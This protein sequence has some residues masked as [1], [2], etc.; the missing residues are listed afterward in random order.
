MGSF[1]SMALTTTCELGI[2]EIIAKAGRGSKLSATDI[3]AQ[4][5]TKNQAAPIMVDRIIETKVMPAGRIANW[6]YWFLLLLTVSVKM[7]S[8]PVAIT[9][10]ESNVVVANNRMI[11]TSFMNK[12]VNVRLDDNNFLLWKQHVLLMIQGHEL[13]ESLSIPPQ[14]I[15]DDSGE[16]IVN[17]TYRQHKK[18]NNS[19]AYWIISIISSSILP[20]LVGAHTSSKIW[21]T[22]LSMYSKLSTTK[23]MSLHGRLRSLK[24]GDFSVREFSTQI[25]EICDLLATSGSLVSEIDHFVTLLNGLPVDFESF[26]VAINVSREPYTFDIVT[27]VLIDVE[28]QIDDLMKTS[29]SISLT[30]HDHYN[31]GNAGGSRDRQSMDTNEMQAN[32]C[33]YDANSNESSYNPFVST[34][35]GGA[36]H[37]VTYEKAR[38]SSGR[39]YSGK[40]KVYLDDGSTLPISHLTQDNNVYLEFHS[41]KCFVKD[42]ETDRIQLEVYLINRLPVDLLGRISPFEKLYGKKPDYQFLRV[43]G[44][45]FF[46]VFDPSIVISLTSGL[47]RVCFLVTHHNIT[48]SVH[49]S[50]VN[51]GHD[52]RLHTVEVEPKVVSRVAAQLEVTRNESMYSDVVLRD[53]QNGSVGTQESSVPSSTD[54]L[55]HKHWCATVEMEFKALI[56]N[57]TWKLVPLPADRKE[58]GYECH[59]EERRLSSSI[60]ERPVDFTDD[61][62]WIEIDENAMTN[63]HLALADEI[64][65][66]KKF[67]QGDSSGAEPAHDEQESESF[68][69]PTTRQSDR[70][71]MRPNWHSNYVIEGNIAY[72]LLTEDGE[73]STFQEPEGFEEK[74]K[75]NLVCRLNKSLYDLKQALRCWYKRFDSFIMCLGYNRLNADPCAYFKRFGDNDF[76]ILL[77]YVDDMLVAGPNKDHIEELKAQLAS[78]FEMKD[79]GSAN[80]ILGIQIHRER[81]NRKIWLSQKNYL[82]NILSRFN[83]QDLGSLMFAM[84]CTRPDIA[85]AVGVVS[86][87][88]EN[89]DKEHW[90]TAKRRFSEKVKGRSTSVNGGVQTMATN[91]NSQTA[92]SVVRYGVTRMDRFGLVGLVQL[93]RIIFGFGLMGAK[94]GSGRI[95]QASHLHLSLSK[96]TSVPISDEIS[97]HLRRYQSPSPAKSFTVKMEINQI[98]TEAWPKQLR[99]SFHLHKE[100]FEDTCFGPW[101]KV[102]HP[103]GDAMLTHLFLQTMTSDLPET[104]Q[105]HDEEIWFD[106]PPAYTCF[107]REE[108]CLITGPTLRHDDVDRYTRHITAYHGFPVFPELST[109]KSNLHV[110]DLTRLLNKKDGFTRMDDVDV[111]RDSYLWR[112]TWNKLSSAFNDRKSLRGDGSKY[113]LSDFIWAFKIWIFEAF[114]A[115]QTYALKTSNDIPRVISWKR[116]RSLQQWEDLLPYTTINNEPPLREPS[117]HPKPSPDRPEYTP[118]QRES[119]PILSHYRASSPPSPHD[120]RPAK[121]PR[122]L[123]PCS[124]SSPPR[125]ELGELRNEVNALREEVGTLRDDNGAWRIKVSTLRGEVAALREIV[126]SLQ[127]ERPAKV[128]A[129][130]RVFLARRSSRIRRRA[131]AITSPFTPIVRRIRKKNPDSPFIVQEASPIVQEAPI[132]PQES[133][134]TVQEATVIVEEVPPNILEPDSHGVIYRIIEKPPHVPDMMDDCWLSYKVFIPVLDRT[135]WLLVELQLPSLKTIVYDSMINYISLSDL[136]DIIK[137]WSSHLAKFLD[138]INYWTNSGNKKP[139]KFNVTVIRDETAPQQTKEAR[140][141]CGPLVCMCLER[142]TTGSTQFLPPTDRDGGAVGLWFRHFM[143]RAIY[144]RRCLPASAL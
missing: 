23:I 60:S 2:L 41:D 66:E 108:F 48:G 7:S 75:K 114:P 97:P 54:A 34:T 84:I 96:A 135:H 119:S 62:K 58:I 133:P 19:L 130:R 35:A 95:E 131:R 107:G 112:A 118:P 63:F 55:Q 141:D 144:A 73:P 32:M 117:P 74:E 47:S 138:A 5:P 59:L 129:L 121:M 101:L 81:S 87:Y 136:R 43:F 85:Q 91:C 92:L 83:M 50:G 123:S 20:Q 51:V 12:Y 36:T 104:I 113:T 61:N 29:I 25:K 89:P 28:S 56:D 110:E 27:S 10:E 57:N 140:G 90:N 124:P 14:N 94:V 134:P 72:C 80:K 22:V 40:C 30:R 76:V 16:L 33:K 79:L 17:P 116:K 103:G 111:V 98:N 128:D 37:H 82:K 53:G 105:R 45:Q 13:D 139:K 11:E 65:V 77:L 8:D 93:G 102:Q 100:K 143:A 44:Y 38:A 88:M 127:N 49:T 71:R 106:F 15:I 125:D 21:N 69:A 109:E 1:L 78:E 132:I 18:Q 52:D 3:A 137:G 46:H 9:S 26:V 39:Q 86:R 6:S 120:R 99:R 115:M 67:E 42:E 142:L 68:E 4:M 122:C 31:G 64:H 126:A 24:K 70:V